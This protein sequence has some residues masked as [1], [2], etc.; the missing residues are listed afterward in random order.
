M[1]HDRVERHVSGVVKLMPPTGEVYYGFVRLFTPANEG[2]DTLRGT[3]DERIDFVTAPHL[4]VPLRSN[5][6]PAQDPI[7]CL[8]RVAWITDEATC[9]SGRCEGGALLL[10]TTLGSLVGRF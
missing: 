3:F 8:I 10:K 9:H 7:R 1:P 2:I 6:H 5:Q 4:I